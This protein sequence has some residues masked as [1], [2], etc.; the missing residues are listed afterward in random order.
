M[1]V[2]P[3][4]VQ[5]AVVSKD[6]FTFSA[7][8]LQFFQNKTQKIEILDDERKMIELTQIDTYWFQNDFP[9]ILEHCIP[10]R[11]L[12]FYADPCR[13]R[14]CADHVFFIYF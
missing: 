4:Y 6:L 8:C 12:G 9:N 2:K 5:E 10:N 11:V 13:P 3:K 1:L 7:V 14:T